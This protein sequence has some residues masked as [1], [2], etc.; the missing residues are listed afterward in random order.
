MIIKSKFFL[1]SSRS[2]DFKLFK[3]FNRFNTAVGGGKFQDPDRLITVGGD[4]VAVQTALSIVVL[5][6]NISFFGSQTQPSGGFGIAFAVVG[7]F[8]HSAAAANKCGNQ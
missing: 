2:G 6:V 1:L 8:R 4:A 7:K 3:Q 5:G